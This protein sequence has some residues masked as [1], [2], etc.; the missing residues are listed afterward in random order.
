MKV[1]TLNDVR[2]IIQ[3]AGFFEAV[4]SSVSD[5]DEALEERDSEDFDKAWVECFN[6]LNSLT[7]DD[8]ADEKIVKELREFSFKKVFSLAHNSEVASYISDDIGLVAD[9]VS[10]T[11]LSGWVSKL[12]EVYLSGEFPR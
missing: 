4:I 2:E 3:E 7:Y 11:T 6:K 12:F 8:L 5:W 10:K 1:E 9:A